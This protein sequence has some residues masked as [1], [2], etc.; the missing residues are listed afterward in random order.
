MTFDLR[1]DPRRASPQEF[2]RH[3]G[4]SLFSQPVKHAR[5]VCRDFPWPVEIRDEWV[6]CGVVW[7]KI[8]HTLQ[9]YITETEW[10]MA[11]DAQ[12]HKIERAVRFREAESGNRDLKPRRI[13][14]LGETT[15]FNGLQKDNRFVREVSI[16]GKKENMDTWVIRLA[17]R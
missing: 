17:R 16:P 14:W 6:T 13:D 12:R 8:Y 7:E 11:S 4:W 2:Y 3:S 9:E 1:K 5:F 10:A 15:V